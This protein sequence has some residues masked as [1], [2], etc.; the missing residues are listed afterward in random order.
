M[1]SARAGV[2]LVLLG[3]GGAALA[4]DATSPPAGA[5]SLAE[6]L[7]DGVQ[8]YSCDAAGG[9]YAWVFR[10]PE[11]ALFD[12]RGRQVGSHGAGPRWT[13]ADGSSVVGEKVAE[14]AAAEPHA[15]PWLLLR[16]KS[17]DGAGQLAAAAWI[18]RTDT[19]GGVAPEGGCDAAHAGETAR[20]RY[21]AIY[22][23]LR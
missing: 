8:V 4:E 13:L 1:K 17:R 16:V 21:S 12:A 18:R 20:M 3:L 6:F 11:A 7:G 10:A 14:S 9:G 23:F 2:L 5:T 19:M 15:I 22:Q